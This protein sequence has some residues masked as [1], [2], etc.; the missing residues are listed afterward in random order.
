MRPTVQ[1]VAAACLRVLVACLPVVAVAFP[2]SATVLTQPSVVRVV[3]G[4]VS[5]IIT[6]RIIGFSREMGGLSGQLF[7]SNLPPGV[8]TDPA[9]PIP[10]G[11]SQPGEGQTTFRFIVGPNTPPGM[12]EPFLTDSNGFGGRSIGLEVVA[13]QTSF[14]AAVSPNPVTL[15]SGAPPRPVTVSTIPQQGFTAPITYAFQGFPSFISTGGPITVTQANGYGPA[16]FQFAAAPGAPPATYN[17]VLL[18]TSNGTT[19]TYPVTVIVQRPDFVATFA[20]P[21][22][23]L[24]NDGTGA[25]NAL[26]LQPLDGYSGSPT[27]T[28]INVPAGITVTPATI[29]SPPLPSMLPFTI[30]AN[31]ASS[32]DRTITA[33]ITDP[34]AGID[35]TVTF[36][37]A[38]LPNDFIPAATGAVNVVAGGPPATITASATRAGCSNANIVVTTSGAPAGVTV[39]PMAVLVAPAYAGVPLTVQATANAAPGA[40]PITLTFTP[41]SGGAAKTLT[42]VVNV[43]A[44]PDFALRVNP[45]AVTLE[46]GQST[47][48]A[49]SVDALNGFSGPVNVTVAPVI[50]VSVSPS[51]FTITPG[52]PQSVT[53]TAQP[54]DTPVTLTLLFSA[55]SAQ[56][57]GV[58]T[59]Q[60]V[61]STSPRAPA[62]I[63]ATPPTVATGTRSI[64]VRLT[65]ANIRPGATITTTRGDVIIE[66]VTLLS[67]TVADVVLSVRSDAA[68]GPV[69]FVVTNPGG[70]RS[71]AVS[72]IVV[73]ATSLSAPLGVSAAL[74]VYPASGTMFTRRDSV[75]PRG[76]LATT[77][78]G[79]VTGAWLLDGVPFDRF[80]VT[81]AGGMPAEVRSH[82]P[83]PWS[84][85]GTHRLEL[86]IDTP[87]Q[88]ISPAVDVLMS[89]A[90]VSRLMVFAPRDGVVATAATLFR[91]SLMP[92]AGGYLVEFAAA[93]E[94][95]APARIRVSDAE[96]RPSAAELAQL[97]SGI[98]RWRVRPVFA[99][100]TEGEP[101]EWRRVAFLPDQVTLIVDP[102][103]GNVVRWRGGV[104]GVLYRVDVVD[105]NGAVLSSALTAAS[106]LTLRD[107]PQG[108]RVRITAIAPGGVVLGVAEAP[109]TSS[110]VTAPRYQ[111][112]QNAAVQ[113]TAR[114]PQ[115]GARI[116]EAQP[117]I[118]ATW[119]GAVRQQ[120][121]TLLLDGMDVTAVAEITPVSIRYDS[122][123]PLAPGSHQVQLALG[124]TTTS[125]QFT[126]E[127]AQAPVGDAAT[128][129]APGA[130]GAPPTAAT[131]AERRGLVRRDWAITPVGSLSVVHGD[132]P[133]AADQV[134]AQLSAN[135]DLGSQST[136]AKVNGDLSLRHD[137]DDPNQTVQESRSWIGAFTGKQGR[138]AEELRVG[139]AVPGFLDQAE[140][141]T[142][143]AARGGVEASVVLPGVRASYYQTFS[144]RPAGLVAGNFGPEQKVQAVALRLPV[145]S[146]WDVRLLGMRVDEQ[147]SL[148]SPGGEGE[149]FGIFGRF[150]VSPAISLLVEAARGSFDQNGAFDEQ[151]GNAFRFGFSGNR[152]TWSYAFNL[153]RTDLGFTNPAN[154]GFTPGAVA[155][156]SGGDLLVTKTIFRSTISVQ[157]RHLQD[158]NSSG[159]VAPQ[160][161][162][163]GGIVSFSAPLG[164]RVMLSLTG[165]STRDRSNG[166]ASLFLPG[167]DRTQQG[168]SATLSETFGRFGFTQTFVQQELRDRLS[169]LM[170][171][172]VRTASLSAAGTLFTNF[173]LSALVSGTRSEGSPSVGTNDILVAS[174]QPGYT[175]QTIG[176]T[177]QPRATYSR[178]EASLG[179]FESRLEQYQMLVSWAPTWLQS[180]A[181]LQLSADWNR[182][183]LTGVPDSGF[184]RRYAAALSLR[185]GASGGAAA[186]ATPAMLPPVESETYAQT[187]PLKSVS[188]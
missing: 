146:R 117:R 2:A 29:V 80:V 21:R 26:S 183:R 3:Q 77:G 154:H 160:T 27:V 172:Q 174:L 114:E 85:I 134:R 47:T 152:G 181:S 4:G 175:I 56:V 136:G 69:P 148:Y 106:E 177:L 90:S 73:P 119:S 38:V 16:T 9:P 109:Q 8:T 64:T 43:A 156:R 44:A 137:L 46:A 12:Y 67:A 79:I 18:A 39:T 53:I 15:Q 58:R 107:V 89:A 28:F 37:A 150:A 57:P 125:W 103:A 7:V 30:S 182:N 111:Y 128:G 123:L 61:V 102:L 166:N 133:D 170:N 188:Q 184:Q 100:E 42:T 186:N 158:G 165:N 110:A 121:V 78:T 65:G 87:R 185:W 72:I 88:A 49:V 81:V 127:A 10:Y 59:A 36:V 97:R 63:V 168:V 48:V 93:G 40:Y 151:E 130:A 167:A 135:T 140:L 115:E 96:W 82:I 164:S 149:A 112:V 84:I 98:H 71:N 161:R 171:Q 169:D 179:G 13:A 113:I 122:L 162:E 75:Y 105:R 41:A 76:V 5:E 104:S 33:R 52:S 11:P 95:R 6:V 159:A 14:E 157:L 139:Y 70:I 25:S 155:D 74:I 176:V 180:Y 108:A 17:G 142:L 173:S 83:V 68:P 124:E 94:E 138:T 62:L 92:N 50:G 22:V 126:V 34:A 178:S 147:P 143:G 131:D 132:G 101:S 23:T 91:W 66:S 145:S 99:G 60:L 35:R 1:T 129:E 45:P 54:S 141:M 51:N 32:G 118:A 120:Q 163:T 19:K 55:T 116:F 20:Q 153:R 187:A 31:G 86:S 24:C 144:S